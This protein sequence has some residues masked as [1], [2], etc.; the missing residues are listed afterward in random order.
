MEVR[1]GDG[2]GV[3]DRKKRRFAMLLNTYNWGQNDSIG[4]L[5]GSKNTIKKTEYTDFP[6]DVLASPNQATYGFWL[7][8]PQ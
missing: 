8:E 6:T 1:P 7:N 5:G 4:L 2:E 3:M